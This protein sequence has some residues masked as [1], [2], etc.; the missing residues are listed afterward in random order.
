MEFMPLN[1]QSAVGSLMLILDA[2]SGLFI[3]LSMTASKYYGLKYSTRFGFL[4]HIVATI[5]CCFSIP[6][7]PKW[8]IE[9]QRFEAAQKSLDTIAKW[10]RRPL[11]FN[12]KDF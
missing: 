10:N 1:K 11:I 4:T 7:S 12:K 8:L 6:E 9:M 2:A 5:A 3:Y